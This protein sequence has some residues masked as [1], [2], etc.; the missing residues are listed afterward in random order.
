MAQPVAAAPAHAHAGLAGL[1]GTIVVADVIQF[2][3]LH[4]LSL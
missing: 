2:D 4:S 3:K 1:A